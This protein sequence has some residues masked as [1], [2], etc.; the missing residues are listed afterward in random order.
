MERWCPNHC[1]N[2]YRIPWEA[3]NS[4]CSF[5]KTNF[6]PS[7]TTRNTSFN[8]IPFSRSSHSRFNSSQIILSWWGVRVMS[9]YHRESHSKRSTW[10]TLHCLF[11]YCQLAIIVSLFFKIF[12]CWIHRVVYSL[13][14]TICEPLRK[15]WFFEMRFGNETNFGRGAERLAFCFLNKY[16]NWF[17]QCLRVTIT[18]SWPRNCFSRLL[19]MSV[20]WD[21]LSL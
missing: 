1:R 3:M 11:Q 4:T 18:M 6:T 2:A 19:R 15:D 21:A 16:W 10:K 7:T 20:L 12:G 8:L 17:R 9:S 14:Q 5:S 13:L